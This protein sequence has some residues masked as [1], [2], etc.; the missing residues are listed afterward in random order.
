MA[1]IDGI[2]H[3]HHPGMLQT[4]SSIVT[5]KDSTRDGTGETFP[6]YNIGKYIQRRVVGGLQHA[7]QKGS[8]EEQAKAVQRAEEQLK[9]W[10]RQSVV[11]AMYRRPQK[12]IMVRIYT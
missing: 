6:D 8:A 9:V 12:S 10:E 2:S 5:R 1:A 4:S 3:Y 7:V 11:Y